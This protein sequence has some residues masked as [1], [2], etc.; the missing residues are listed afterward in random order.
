MGCAGGGLDAHKAAPLPVALSERINE[1]AF[2]G[3]FRQEPVLI[4]VG[5]SFEFLLAFA[6]DDDQGSVDAV[7]EGI[8]ITGRSAGAG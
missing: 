8:R 4:L 1:I 2:D 5:Q 6:G 3:R 7:F